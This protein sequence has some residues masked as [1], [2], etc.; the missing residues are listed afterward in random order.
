MISVSQSYFI[1]NYFKAW[2][3]VMRFKITHQTL[4]I[5]TIQLMQTYDSKKRKYRRI[6]R[7]ENDIYQLMCQP[8]PKTKQN[9]Q[10]NTVQESK[11]KAKSDTK[12]SQ[13]LT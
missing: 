5:F 4:P 7:F 12:V 11:P 8:Y 10:K 6:P 3:Q 9:K 1:K 13:S 2:H